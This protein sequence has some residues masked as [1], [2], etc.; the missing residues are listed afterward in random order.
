MLSL[1]YFQGN[2]KT[3]VQFFGNNFENGAGK[4]LYGLLDKKGEVIIPAKY[5]QLEYDG[6]KRFAF[7]KIDMI[8]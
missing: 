6:N 4:P 3:T 7:C 2:G 5:P 1:I 8:Q